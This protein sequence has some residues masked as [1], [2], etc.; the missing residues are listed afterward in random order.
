MENMNINGIL[1]VP[2]NLCFWWCSSSEWLEPVEGEGETVFLP[3]PAL[4]LSEPVGRFLPN[5]NLPDEWLLGEL[6]GK[7]F[8]CSM[9]LIYMIVIQ[10]LSV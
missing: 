6:F 9:I 1:M 2:Y 8:I 4:R 10:R 5:L 7:L 3:N